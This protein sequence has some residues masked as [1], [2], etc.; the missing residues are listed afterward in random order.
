MERYPCSRLGAPPNLELWRKTDFGCVNESYALKDHRKKVESCMR[1]KIF[2]I[3]KYRD[4][5]NT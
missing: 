4:S 2:H 5:E 3:A 1:S